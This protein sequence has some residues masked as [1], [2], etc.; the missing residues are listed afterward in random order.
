[1][2]KGGFMSDVVSSAQIGEQHMALLSA[3]TIDE[4]QV[5]LLPARNTMDGGFWDAIFGMAGKVIS[6]DRALK[7]DITPVQWSR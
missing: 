5:E 6:S 4:Q 3:S 7:R 2:N 1:M